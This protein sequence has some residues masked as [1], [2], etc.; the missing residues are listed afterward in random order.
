MQLFA[1]FLVLLSIFQVAIAVSEEF[2]AAELVVRQATAPDPCIDYSVTANMSV[3][4][5]NSSYRAAFMQKAPVGTLVSAKMLNDAQ[6]KLP[7]LTVN[8]ELNSQ[9]G[10]LTT[11]ALTE[12]E[13]NFTNGIVGPFTTAEGLPVGITAGP[14]VI[15]IVI[16]CCTI[17]SSVWVFSG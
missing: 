3:I 11:L 13:K 17:M 5:A 12:A 2:P 4:S 6:A 9:C 8:A 1:N 10:N 14:E 7:A 15:V 16:A